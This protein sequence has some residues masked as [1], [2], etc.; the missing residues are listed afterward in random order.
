VRRCAYASLGQVARG[1]EAIVAF[2]AGYVVLIAFL[3]WKGMRHFSSSLPG[4]ATLDGE[5]YAFGEDANKLGH[6]LATRVALTV[7][8]HLRFDVRREGAFDRFAKRIGIAREWEIGDPSIDDHLYVDDEE[9]FAELMAT[10]ADVRAGVRGLLHRLRAHGAKLQWLEC[11]NGRLVLQAHTGFGGRPGTVRDE[12]VR[13]LMPLVRALRDIERPLHASR[14]RAEQ[15]ARLPL[16]VVLGALVT[17]AGGG[18]G[19]HAFLPQRLV[20]PWPLWRA[21]WIGGAVL[22]AAFVLW[23]TWRVG[24]TPR[25][26]RL[27]LQW[28]LLGMPAFGGLSAFATRIVDVAADRSAPQFIETRD[29]SVREAY[30]RRAGTE[31]YVAFASEDPRLAGASPLRIDESTF[32]RLRRGWNAD[33]NEKLTIAWYPGA[34]G[35]PWVEVWN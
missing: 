6:V 30:R 9:V 32:L 19:L 4:Q 2:I 18:L 10:R 1:R 20:D 7:P 27:L 17:G 16:A 22:L 29:A 12:A 11:A 8:R 21:G 28:L 5:R 26:H 15:R 25:R 35:L 33:R 31:Y 23:A 3:V 14:P 34:L 24:A 13:F